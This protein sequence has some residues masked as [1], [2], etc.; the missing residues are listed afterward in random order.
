MAGE[1]RE[2]EIVEQDTFARRRV[3]V[4][5][6]GM[7][8]N[9]RGMLIESD[10]LPLFLQTAGNKLKMKKACKAFALDGQPIESIDQVI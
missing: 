3:T 6:N 7:K 8:S 1:E 10:N 2:K 4:Y 5:K 9:G